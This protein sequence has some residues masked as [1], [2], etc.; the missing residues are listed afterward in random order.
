ML[1]YF[2][3]AAVL[4]R[5]KDELYDSETS[6]PNFFI[7]NDDMTWSTSF[8]SATQTNLDDDTVAGDQFASS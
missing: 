5:L 1:R 6:D 3:W 2:I 8:W 7:S 4:Q